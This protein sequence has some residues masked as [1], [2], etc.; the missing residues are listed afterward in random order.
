MTINVLIQLSTVVLYIKR[1]AECTLS[2]CTKHCSGKDITSVITS[3]DLKSDIPKLVVISLT[4]KIKSQVKWPHNTDSQGI[5]YLWQ[6]LT[7]FSKALAFVVQYEAEAS[8]HMAAAM[9]D[10]KYYSHELQKMICSRNI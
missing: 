1:C 7:T 4:K 8:P 3:W 10:L 2:V 9:S 6:D 5:F